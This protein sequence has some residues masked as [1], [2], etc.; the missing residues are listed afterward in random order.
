MPDPRDTRRPPKLLFVVSEDWYF[1]SHRLPLAQAALAEGFDVAVATRVTAHGDAIRQAG[2]RAIP[3]G[4]ERRSMNVMDELRSILELRRIIAAE[5]PDI[6]HNVAIKPI[7]HGSIAARL[8][9][10]GAIVN[11]IAGLGY[12]FTSR[13]ARARLAKP[14]VA[15]ALRWLLDGRTTRVIV[16]NPEDRAFLIDR[17][18]ARSD[19]ISLI[20]G[21]GVDTST[22]FPAAEPTGT[23]VV[24]L[25]SRMLRDK[26]VPDFVAAASLLLDEGV[27]ARFVLVGGPDPGN[28]ASIPENELRKLAERPGI[29]WWGPRSDMPAVFGHAHIVCLPTTYGEGI[30]KVLLE[31]ASCGRAIIASDVQGCREIVQPGVNGLLVPPCDPAAIAAA[32][33]TLLL[34]AATR[35]RMGEAGRGLVQ[36]EFG[37]GHVTAAT[38]TIYRELLE[39]ISFSADGITKRT[40][41]ARR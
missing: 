14:V 31:A 8:A 37:I 30:P 24:M 5:T 33:R 15:F 35:R 21:S 36:R 40:G 9:G 20:R 13:S 16:Q 10:R 3:I 27:A 11:A 26:G 34:D 1:C 6:I 12:V 4:M 23:P 28:P 19:R 39:G 22:F 38:M 7:L 32:I 2:I 17:G 18:M 25:A 41:S 29:E